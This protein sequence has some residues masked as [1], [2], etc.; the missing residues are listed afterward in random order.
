MIQHTQDRRP[1][2]NPGRIW[3]DATLSI[4]NVYEGPLPNRLGEIQEIAPPR[5]DARYIYVLAGHVGGVGPFVPLYIGKAYSPHNRFDKHRIKPW[6]P[7]VSALVLYRHEFD[8]L[9][10]TVD[11]E[12]DELEREAI[13]DFN[14]HYNISRPLPQRDKG[15]VLSW[16]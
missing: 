3:F 6:W 12:T 2:E 9:A 15:G 4:D 7:E 8:G 10:A 1:V 13:A 5:Y 14:P 11:R 16:R